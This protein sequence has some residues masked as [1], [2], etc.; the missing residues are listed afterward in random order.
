MNKQPTTISESIKKEG[1][2]GFL[3]RW[4]TGINKIPP[5]QLVFTEL[6][7]GIGSTLGMLLAFFYFIFIIKNMWAI[8]IPLFFGMVMQAV[9]VVSKYQQYT[10]LKSIKSMTAQFEQ[11]NLQ[12]VK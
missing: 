7:S 12:E 8:S 3:K 10:A 11:I 9:Q 1:I 6:I 4:K 5:E 2:K